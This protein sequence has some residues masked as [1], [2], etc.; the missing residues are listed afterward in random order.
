MLCSSQIEELPMKA[1][2]TTQY[3][4][5]DVLQLMEITTPAPAVNQVLIKLYAS[6]VNPRQFHDEGAVVLS[7]GRGQAAQA[8]TQGHRR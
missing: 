8:K 4:P 7:P 2:V 3:G 5:P 1:I 6:S